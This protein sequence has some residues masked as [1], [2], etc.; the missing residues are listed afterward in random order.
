MK[1]DLLRSTVITLLSYI[2]L[3]P[4]PFSIIFITITSEPAAFIYCRLLSSII[5]EPLLN[6]FT[7]SIISLLFFI[8]IVLSLDIMPL[9]EEHIFSLVTFLRMPSTSVLKELSISLRHHRLY[10]FLLFLFNIIYC[11]IACL[12]FIRYL[13]CHLLL[14]FAFFCCYECFPYEVQLGV[15]KISHLFSITT[16]YVYL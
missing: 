9:G 16:A 10:L 5:M 2:S 14:F 7:V 11:T 13:I 15:S 3:I 6:S 4:N 8:M 12:S 1:I